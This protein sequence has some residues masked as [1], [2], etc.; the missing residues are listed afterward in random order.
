[1][2]KVLFLFLITLGACSPKYAEYSY[3]ADYSEYVKEGFLIYPIGTDVKE[4]GYIPIADIELVFYSGRKSKA[5]EHS[6]ISPIKTEE[7]SSR[8]I[9][10]EQYI[11]EKIVKAAKERNANGILNY[12]TIALR[13]VKGNIR[14]YKVKGTAIIINK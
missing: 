11:T 10:T 6:G 9:P 1:M 7:G 3:I 14:C 5:A 2:K 4:V 13:D 8:Y 12:Q